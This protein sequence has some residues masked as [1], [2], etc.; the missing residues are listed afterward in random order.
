MSR[1]FLGA[2]VLLVTGCPN[3]ATEAAPEVSA[4]AAA[5]YACPMHPNITSDAPGKCSECGMNLDKV[6][7]HDHASHPHPEDKKGGKAEHKEGGHGDHA[8]ENGH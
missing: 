6:E 3:P 2:L 8:G 7:E 4:A 1:I 5:T